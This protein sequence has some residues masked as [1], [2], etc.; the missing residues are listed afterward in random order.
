[1]TSKAATKLAQASERTAMLAKPKRTPSDY[2][3]SREVQ[4]IPTAA[5]RNTRPS[6]RIEALAE[7]KKQPSGPFREPDW[8]VSKKAMKA[9]PIMRESMDHVQFNPDVFKVSAAAQKAKC[10]ARTAELAQPIVK[11]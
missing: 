1:M 11:S 6:E 5:A 4:S 9:Q 10:S 7:A 2:E 3:E 8:P